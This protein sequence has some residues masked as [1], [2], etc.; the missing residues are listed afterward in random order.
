MYLTAETPRCREKHSFSAPRRL[1]GEKEFGVTLVE[2]MIVVTLIGLVVG[3][4]FPSVSAGIDGLRLS[5]A[6]GSLVSFLNGALNRAERRREPVEV[7]ISLAQSSLSLLSGEPGFTRTLQMPEGVKITAIRPEPPMGETGIRRFLLMPG[8]VPPG[9]GI[10]ISNQKGASRIV[11]IDPVVGV[12]VI[13]M[14]E[15]R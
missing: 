4:S 8:G 9:I 1:G 11:R 15:P 7:T 5:S 2:M 3:L 14:P 13:E 12:P 10:E 6:A